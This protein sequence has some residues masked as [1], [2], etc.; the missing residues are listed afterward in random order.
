MPDVFLSQSTQEHN[1]YTGGG[2]EEQEMG[3]WVALVKPMLEAHGHRVGVGST[4]SWS[5]NVARG[6]KFM[7]AKGHYYAFHTNAGGGRGTLVLYHAGSA[8]GRVMADKVSARVCPVSP[9][10]DVGVRGADQYGELNGPDSPSIIIEAEYHDWIFGAA[11]IKNNPMKYATAIAEGILDHIGRAAAPGPVTP[12]VITPK[13][14]TA[15][16]YPLGPKQYFGIGQ[17]VSMAK[18]GT[19]EH[20]WVVKI[21]RAVGAS[22]DGDYGPDTAKH[23]KAAQMRHGI[24]QDG[25]VGP[26]S[27]AHFGL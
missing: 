10:K 7:G 9:G 27:W 12:P 13:P 5:D 11:D 18:E 14:S 17:H 15:T 22:P 4:I 2:N 20:A 1:A 19:P 26:T 8:E 25:V 23:V 16:K 3:E 24:P 6:N 21:Q